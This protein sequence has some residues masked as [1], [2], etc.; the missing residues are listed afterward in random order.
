MFLLSYI[1][2]EEMLIMKMLLLFK[3]CPLFYH[4]LVLLY[5]FCSV[6]YLKELFYTE[7]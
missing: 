6:C 1:Y 3:R 4:M 7:K 2:A 5:G